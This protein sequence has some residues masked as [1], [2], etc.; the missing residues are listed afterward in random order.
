MMGLPGAFYIACVHTIFVHS[1][2]FLCIET[3]RPL[4]LEVITFDV[5]NEIKCYKVNANII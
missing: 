5:F 4:V 2:R 3:S 1:A